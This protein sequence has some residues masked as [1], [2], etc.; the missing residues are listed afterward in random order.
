MKARLLLLLSLLAAIGIVIAP[1]AALAQAALL[2]PAASASQAPPPPAVEESPDSPRVS[3]RR[4]Q[5]LCARGAY[6]EAAAYLDLSGVSS[7]RAAELARRLDIVLRHRLWI[8]PE[9][10]SGASEGRPEPNVPAGVEEL[11]RIPDA[12]GRS[13]AVR[14][15]RRPPQ[16]PDEEAR[17]VFSRQT[18]MHID[19]WYD[20]VDAQWIHARLPPYLLRTGPKSLLYWQ[21]LA[22]PV[23]A[24]LSYLIGRAAAWLGGR[25]VR[26]LVS[27]VRF[28]TPTIDRLHGPARMAWALATFYALV[29]Y[30]YLYLRAA[31]LVNRL[32]ASLAWLCFFWGLVRL[33]S[34]GGEAISK[35]A[36]VDGRPSASAVVTLATRVGKVVIVALAFM[37][38]LSQLGYPVTSVVAGLGIGGIALALAAQKTV[39]N[40]FGSVSIVVDRPFTVGEWIKVEGVEGTV[41]SI[42]LRSTRIR[43]L[44]RTLVVFPNGKLAELRIEAFG[45]REKYRFH[46]MLDLHKDTPPEVA[47]R[48]VELAREALLRHDKTYEEGVRAW[49]H[50]ITEN[51]ISLEL[52]VYAKTTNVMEFGPIRHELLVSVLQA[53]AAAGARLSVPIREELAPGGPAAPPSAEAP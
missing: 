52:A 6:G 14:I 49:V 29:P 36:W 8:D 44:D 33:V 37:V 42:G 27:R 31:E 47:S 11:G 25:I 46:T 5:N 3:M 30:L 40:L 16:T 50:S 51:A 7:K 2:K 26:R 38:A 20:D 24:F 35:A 10:L 9:L 28:A 15:V 41:E 23:L 53:V 39:E 43:T 18:V 13:V 19:E 1:R 21:W 45:T 48:A 34:V 32:L 4:Y 17:W 22:I 12:K